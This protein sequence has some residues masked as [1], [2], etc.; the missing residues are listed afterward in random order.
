MTYGQFGYI[1]EDN[2]YGAE[3]IRVLI[4]LWSSCDSVKVFSW[5]NKI[6]I[7]CD[8]CHYDCRTKA[9]ISKDF[10]IYW[11]VGH[12]LGC[13]FWKA[14]PKWD[15]NFSPRVPLVFTFKMSLILLIISHIIIIRTI[16]FWHCKCKT[17]VFDVCNL[18]HLK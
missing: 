14:F 15:T 18:H 12:N 11:P 16:F 2:S 7:L 3:A 1:F 5:Q 9:F 6:S 17:V 8:T 10:A 4:H 13:V